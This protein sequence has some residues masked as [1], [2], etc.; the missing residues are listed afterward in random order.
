MP[1]DDNGP[2]LTDY[3]SA[4]SRIT[5]LARLLCF[6]CKLLEQNKIEITGSLKYWWEEHKLCDALNQ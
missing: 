1:C 6:A 4:V 5:D 3:R 2:T